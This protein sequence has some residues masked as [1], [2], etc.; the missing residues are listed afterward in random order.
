MSLAKGV[1]VGVHSQLPDAA[2]VL[3]L[4]SLLHYIFVLLLLEAGDDEGVFEVGRG[5][6]IDR[7]D[8]V[9]HCQNFLTLAYGGFVVV[10]ELGVDLVPV[11]FIG[12]LYFAG[13]GLFHIR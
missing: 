11:V 7:G 5:G 1:A 4:I 13:D 3:H 6:L 12:L 10:D 9:V 8:F 2:L